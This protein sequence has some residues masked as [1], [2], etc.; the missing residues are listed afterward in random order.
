VDDISQLW[1][2]I[3][4]TQATLGGLSRSAIYE[5]IARGDLVRVKIGRRSFITEQSIADYTQRV[6]AASK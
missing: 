3:P 5:L 6:E 4:K 2:S 1:L